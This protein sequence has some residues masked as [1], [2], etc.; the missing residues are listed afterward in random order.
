MI[1]DH[2]DKRMKDLMASYS[3]AKRILWREPR[4]LKGK[5]LKKKKEWTNEW[6]RRHVP[7]HQREKGRKGLSLYRRMKE[8]VKLEKKSWVVCSSSSRTLWNLTVQILIQLGLEKKKRG[9]LHGGVLHVLHRWILACIMTLL[10]LDILIQNLVL[11][12]LY[13]K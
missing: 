9:F 5:R 2:S 4:N 7:N 12:E 6:K 8:E 1:E 10:S 3:K 11:L 13:N